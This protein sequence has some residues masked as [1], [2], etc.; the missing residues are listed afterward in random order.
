MDCLARR[1]SHNW[2]KGLDNPILGWRGKAEFVRTSLESMLDDGI[3]SPDG[4]FIVGQHKS[5]GT[6]IWSTN[7]YKA[8]QHIPKEEAALAF[9]S[10]GVLTATWDS[11]HLRTSIYEPTTGAKQAEFHLNEIQVEEYDRKVVSSSDGSVLVLRTKDG[12]ELWDCDARGRLAT[13]PSCGPRLLW[14]SP[15]GRRLVTD[16]SLKRHVEIWTFGDATPRRIDNGNSLSIQDACVSPDDATLAVSS[17]DG[18]VRLWDIASGKLESQLFG[19]KQANG[20]VEFSPD[21]R[22]LVSASGRKLRFW[23]TATQRELMSFD[24]DFPVDESFPIS[25]SADGRFMTVASGHEDTEIH[26]AP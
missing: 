9:T 5:K 23:H 21:G 14:L 26:A 20:S 19:A 16:S 1:Q 10:K 6:T 2:G 22:T 13:Y 11:G 12:L 24:Y 3:F 4:E 7:S 8:V 18:F 15:D 17:D 25:F